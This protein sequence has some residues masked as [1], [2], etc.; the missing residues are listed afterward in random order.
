MGDD[1]NALAHCQCLEG[2]Q[3]TNLTRQVGE[4]V[5]AQLTRKSQSSRGTAKLRLT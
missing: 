5:L 2:S 1:I 3:Q 4:L